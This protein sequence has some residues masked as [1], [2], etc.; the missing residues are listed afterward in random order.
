MST[1][2]EKMVDD[3]ARETLALADATGDAELVN[4]MSRVLAASSTT[5]QEAFMAAIRLRQAVARGTM[6][7]QQRSAAA[8]AAQQTPE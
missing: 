5:T 2:H 7:L 6:F 3:L 4:E 8:K 1:T